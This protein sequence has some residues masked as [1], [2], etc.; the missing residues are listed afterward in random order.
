MSEATSSAAATPTAGARFAGGDQSYRVLVWRR[1]R[2]SVAG[3]TGLVLVALV[4]VMAVF[5]DFVAPLDP[6]AVDASF[7]PPDT[8]TFFDGDGNFSIFPR[9]YPVVESDL[10][11]IHI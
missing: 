9:I 4:L 2:R 5:A 11:L 8:V 6:H 3:M 1:L 10:S 7:T